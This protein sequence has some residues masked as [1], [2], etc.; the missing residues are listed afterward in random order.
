MCSLL[1]LGDTTHY[2]D[3]RPHYSNRIVSDYTFHSLGY[4]RYMTKMCMYE[5]S[6]FTKEFEYFVCR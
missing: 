6:M 1:G 5:V 3:S 4:L 2:H